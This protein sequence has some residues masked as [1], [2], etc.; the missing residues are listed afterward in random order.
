MKIE[1]KSLSGKREEVD[2]DPSITVAEF[3]QFL[4]DKDSTKYQ[5]DLLKLIFSGKIFADDKTIESYGVKEG[6]KI[7]VMTMKKKAAPAATATTTTAPAPVAAAAP[8]IPQTPAVQ[9]PQTQAPAAPQ[10]AG[11]EI[12]A[13]AVS[14]LVSMGFPEAEVRAALRAAW[15]NQQRAVEFLT[16]GI[17]DSARQQLEA[18]TAAAPTTTAPTTAAPTAGDVQG[19]FATLRNHPQF[20]MMQQAARANPAVI[21]QIIERL[22][23]AQPALG[24][25]IRA[26]QDAFVEFL[27][28]GGDCE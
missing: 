7:V 18:P 10:R 23:E 3:K 19:L 6:S 1:L 14:G 9:A 24:N 28:G 21:P 22:V 17:P 15:G 4:Q 12:S 11:P 8:V 27:S 20:Q 25:M 13:E 5:K 16:T 26:N 2:V